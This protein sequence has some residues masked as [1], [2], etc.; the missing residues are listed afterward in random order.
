MSKITNLFLLPMLCSFLLIFSACNEPTPQVEQ[1]PSPNSFVSVTSSISP[2][3]TNATIFNIKKL[4]DKADYSA[5]TE[6]EFFA[7]WAKNSI[8]NNPVLLEIIKDPAKSGIHI[9]G[10]IAYITVAGENNTFSNQLIFPIA[11]QEK[12][13]KAL[14]AMTTDNPLQDKG[15]YQ[16][17]P[18]GSN[19]TLVFNATKGALLEN[20][21]E[22]TINSILNPSGEGLKE[23]SNFAKQ[24]NTNSD[25]LVWNNSTNWLPLLKL[26]PNS[27]IGISFAQI[28]KQDLNDNYLTYHYTFEDG[29]ANMKA[30][31]ELNPN[32]KDNL[33]NWLADNITTDYSD[34]FPK[35]NLLL[36]M[37]MGLDLKGILSF[38]TPRGLIPMANPQTE[39]SVGLTLPQIEQSLAGDL[40]VGLYAT[41][42]GS[43]AV[44][45]A[46]GIKDKSL[47]EN[48]LFKLGV[49]KKGATWSWTAKNEMDPTGKAVG[50]TLKMTDDLLIA[51]TNEA[52]L[53]KAIKGGQDNN[54]VKDITTGWLGMYLDFESIQSN[55][56]QI[57]MLIGRDPSE[58]S[59]IQMEE[60]RSLT[61]S[62][63]GNNM[64]SSLKTKKAD[65]NS[66]KTI[67]T[68]MNNIYKAQENAV[69]EF[70]DFDSEFGESTTDNK[71]I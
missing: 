46:I 27:E 53:A 2:K 59:P 8:K 58:L 11:D 7:N 48:A 49:E 56:D 18:L 3:A 31:T 19:Q 6:M 52:L 45:F 12:M 62:A 42:T 54:I 68:M 71:T 34:V 67:I 30:T 64:T 51:S 15:S 13:K 37:N 40:S 70:D 23:N 55:K 35:E 17:M 29:T 21:D 38:M 26:I 33:G 32:L 14:A 1:M 36:N 50:Y 28:S 69:D 24:Y 44:L 10:E 20:P 65:V 25:I 39:K 57:A 66:L 16:M 41:E 22:A 5:V 63:K 47:V 43:A 4:L 60:L 9:N 61:F